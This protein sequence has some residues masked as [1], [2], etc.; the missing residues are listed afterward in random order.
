MDVSK[1]LDTQLRYYQQFKIEK[2]KPRWR[3]RNQRQQRKDVYV[4]LWCFLISKIFH[5]LN[6]L[7]LIKL[8]RLINFFFFCDT[9]VSSFLWTGSHYVTIFLQ[10]KCQ[11][12]TNQYKTTTFFPFYVCLYMY[13]YALKTH[14]NTHI[15]YTYIHILIFHYL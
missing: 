6:Q 14:T 11:C 1:L 2:P 15:H 9:L 10:K 7:R 4:A 13:V 8:I 5:L 3:H 12:L